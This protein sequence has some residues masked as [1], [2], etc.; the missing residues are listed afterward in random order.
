MKLS[1]G[2]IALALLFTIGGAAHGASLD[3][4]LASGPK[5]CPYLTSGHGGNMNDV[6]LAVNDSQ[7]AKDTY[8]RTARSRRA[9]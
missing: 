9:Q 2:L 7:A 4:N 1:M 6:K 3:P 8:G 5:P